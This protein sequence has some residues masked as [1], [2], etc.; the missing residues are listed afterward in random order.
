[1]ESPPRARPHALPRLLDERTRPDFRDCFGALARS[2]DA[3]DLAITR[4]RLTTIRLEVG[5]L[6]GLRRMRLLLAEVRA[7][8]LDAEAHEALRDPGRSV[9]VR[10]LIN[11]LER[12]RLQVRAAPLGGW[13]PDFSV[14]H[15][16]RRPV[17]ALL[18]AHW[19]ERPY[20]YRGPAWAV[21]LGPADARRTSA[22]FDELWN[23]SHDVSPA[24]RRLL[25]RAQAETAP[26]GALSPRAGA[27]TVP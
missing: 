22:R 5:E 17:G 15:R 27:V 21:W 7:P 24:L 10:H 11:Q 13:S 18:G 9:T 19:L 16:D 4:V 25:E 26:P 1:M 2:A 12:G 8:R 23:R 20:P 3:L 14:F 6:A